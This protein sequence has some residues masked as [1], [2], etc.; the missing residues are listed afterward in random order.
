MFVSILVIVAEC[1]FQLSIWTFVVS[2]EGY[3][4]S[5]SS[6]ILLTHAAFAVFSL[7]AWASEMAPPTAFLSLSL[8]W[9]L[10]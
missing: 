1:V 5:V 2:Y 6:H 10:D 9:I 7:L 4:S 8:V 3:S